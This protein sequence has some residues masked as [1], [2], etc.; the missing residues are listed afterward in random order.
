MSTMSISDPQ[1][2]SNRLG[3]VKKMTEM[4][5]IVCSTTVSL[6]AFA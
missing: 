3:C 2:S 1:I 4:R 5:S 6:Y